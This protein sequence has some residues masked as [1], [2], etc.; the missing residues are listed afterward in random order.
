MAARTHLTVIL[1]LLV[2]VT[3]LSWYLGTGGGAHPM[4][5]NLTI[6]AAVLF[7]ALLKVR[8]IMSEFMDVGT[9]PAW[10]RRAS[11][12]WLVLFFAALFMVHIAVSGG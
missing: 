7:I 11:N 1:V 8:L 3:V 12:A 10:V 4:A 6:S 2:S 5:P 9:A